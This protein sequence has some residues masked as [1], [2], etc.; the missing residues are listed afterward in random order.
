MLVFAATASTPL[1]VVQLSGAI[2]VLGAF[3]C[4][5][6]GFMHPRS[7]SYLVMNVAGA[8]MLAVLAAMGRQYGFLL[9]EAVWTVVSVTSLVQELSRRRP[10]AALRS[11]ERPMR[12]AD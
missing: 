3:A 1:Q 2:L 11:R 5:Q 4:A 9:L 10:S 7:L 12:A 8:G 6:Y